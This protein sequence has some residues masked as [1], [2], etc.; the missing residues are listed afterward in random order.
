VHEVHVLA[1]LDCDHII[2]YYDCFIENVRLS[3][4]GHARIWSLFSRF[5]EQQIGSRSFAEVLPQMPQ[6]AGRLGR[7]QQR[8][9]LLL[10]GFTAAEHAA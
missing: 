4:R 10:A 7:N 1:K 6:L 9:A 8:V 2:R 5:A 3:I